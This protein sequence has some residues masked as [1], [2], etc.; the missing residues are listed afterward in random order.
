MTKKELMNMVKAFGDAADVDFSLNS[1]NITLKDF[2][3]FTEDYEEIYNEEM[4]EKFEAFEE[5]L[6]EECLAM[7][8][9]SYAKNCYFFK[10]YTIVIRYTSWDI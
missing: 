7:D 8:I 2:A 5:K 1:I 3:G 6:A 10:D 9:T 4:E